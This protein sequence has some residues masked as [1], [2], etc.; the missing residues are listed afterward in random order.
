MNK[1]KLIWLLCFVAMALI[2]ALGAM[3]RIDR[4]K[5]IPNPICIGAQGK[6][7]EKSCGTLWYFR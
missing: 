2:C 4:D 6:Q 3:A 5:N 7:V 1:T